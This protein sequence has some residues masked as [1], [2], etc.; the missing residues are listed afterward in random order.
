MRHP[1]ERERNS[2]VRRAVL[3]RVVRASAFPASYCGADYSPLPRGAH[4]HLG[5][6]C[7]CTKRDRSSGHAVG[8][9]LEPSSELRQCSGE[10]ELARHAPFSSCQAT[11]IS[12]A[13][14][15]SITAQVQ[16]SA[17]PT[18]PSRSL[19]HPTKKGPRAGPSRV[20]TKK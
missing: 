14:P 2:A 7:G 6:S 18:E 13:P 5:V 3:P 11:L 15:T 4:S 1:N 17:V 9:V 19:P 10:H 8:A 12:A 16:L 20:V